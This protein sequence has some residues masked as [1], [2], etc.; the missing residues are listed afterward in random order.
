VNGKSTA[1]HLPI[2]NI[3]PVRKMALMIKD[4]NKEPLVP[5]QE[6]NMLKRQNNGKGVK[7]NSDD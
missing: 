7:A 1:P 2:Q 3:S 4:N 5:V 6:N